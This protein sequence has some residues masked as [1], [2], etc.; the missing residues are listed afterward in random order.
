MLTTNGSLLEF[1]QPKFQNDLQLCYVA[2]LEND[3][4]LNYTSPKV[5][6]IISTIGVNNMDSV[7][8]RTLLIKHSIYPSVITIIG[9]I[10]NYMTESI[11][12]IKKS[13]YKA[14]EIVI[15]KKTVL[16]SPKL[17]PIPRKIKGKMTMI[18]GDSIPFV[19]RS[20]VVRNKKIISTIETLKSRR[21]L[22][23]WCIASAENISIFVAYFKPKGRH[24]LGSIIIKKGNRYIFSDYLA[25]YTYDGLNIW[26][27]GD[28][29]LFHESQ[30]KVHELAN[31]Q[32]QTELI[33]EWKGQQRDNIYRLVENEDILVKDF[34]K[35]EGVL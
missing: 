29:G 1:V 2:V 8:G 20:Y 34:I 31:M 11:H 7:K 12:S 16:K 14:K 28:K 26:R 4:A 21:L 18:Y 27:L 22:N 30:F 19:Q 23:L 33:L 35:D 24:Y 5:K 6:E 17:V 32:G 15:G 3:I 25:L 9:P 10:V 13:Y